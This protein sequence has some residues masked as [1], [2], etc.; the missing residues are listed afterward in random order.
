MCLVMPRLSVR[1]TRWVLARSR[2][3]PNQT[4][5][6]SFDIG[7]GAAV[8]FATTNP[9]VVAAGLLAFHLHVLLDYTSSSRKAAR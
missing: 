5:V 2:L 9:V 7:I 6:P 1:V 3:S 4:T 8:A